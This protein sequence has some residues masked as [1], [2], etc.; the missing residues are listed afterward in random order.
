[1][2]PVRGSVVLLALA[3]TVASAPGSARANGRFPRAERL[4]EREGDPNG[5]VLSATYGLLF[6]GDRGGE[7]RHLCDLGF[8][9]ANAELDPMVGV[10][11]DGS[12]IVKGIRSLNRAPPPGCAFEAV[13]GGEGTDTV[14]D[15]TL[16]RSAPNRVLALLMDRGDDGGVENR[17]LESTDAARTFAPLGVP[18]PEAEV[19]F[20]ITLDVAPSDPQRL[21]VT[22]TGRDVAD[23]F[24]RSD[25]GAATWSTTPLALDADE[26]P[27]IAAVHPA[28]A[29]AVYV[30][31]DLWAATPDGYYEANDGLFYSDDG[32]TSFREI[33]RAKAKLFG[34]ALSPDGSEVLVGYGDPVDPGGRLVDPAALGIYRARTADFAFEKIYDGGVSCLSWTSTGLYVCTSQEERGFALGFSPGPDFDLGVADPFTPLLDLRNV[35]GPLE[36][37]ACSSGASCAESW[38]TTCAVLGS[39]D[40]GVAT[41]GTS[42][43]NCAGA[44]GASTGAG[45]APGGASGTGAMAGGGAGGSGGAAKTD[46]SCG[47]R[48]AGGATRERPWF[49]LF[50]ILA[51]ACRIVRRR[52]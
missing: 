22:A 8:A 15:F 21:Y 49:G 47:C 17:V 19:T 9:F 37:P 51:C 10:F 14:A 36:C 18:L 38:A 26:N 5:L 24:V 44:G 29:D 27:Y 23:V 50:L 41:G 7:W 43:G 11:P 32:G 20:G 34:F 13:L 30:R 31:T 28:N 1:M 40:A 52:E 4:L 46:G 25:D 2:P 45:G 42:G 33:F 35:A 12:T 3:F 39:C 48:A 16:D 6:T